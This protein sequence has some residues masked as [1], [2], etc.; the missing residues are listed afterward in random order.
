MPEAYHIL[1]FDPPSSINFGWSCFRVCDGEATLADSGVEILPKS[2]D[3][4]VRL[5][6]VERFVLSLFGRFPNIRAMCFERSIGGGWAPTRENL[7]ECTGVIKLIGG[8]QDVE[9]ISVHTGQMAKDMTGSA[10]KIGKKTRIKRI[11][12]DIF[13]PE[14]KTFIEIASY[15]N[16]EG[17]RIEFLEHQADAIFLGAHSL[18][19]QGVNVS[20]PG[21]PLHLVQPDD[22]KRVRK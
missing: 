11:V 5:L 20:G 18:L 22:G 14:S 17:K 12:K 2:D 19:K 1:G 15:V 13:F 6:H 3:A 7:A 10:T 8:H 9:I 21:G 16:D 4:R